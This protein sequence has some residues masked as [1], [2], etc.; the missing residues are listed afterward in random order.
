MRKQPTVES[1]DL[2]VLGGTVL[3]VDARDTVVSD[4]AVAI[5]DGAIVEVGPR[6]K[7]ERRFRARRSIDARGRLVLP[8]F[9]NAHTH[10]AMTL[11]RGVRDDV[12]LMTWL[13]KYM[14]PLERRFVTREFVRWGTRLACWEMIASGTTTF[15][16]GYFF[17]E[18]VA[19]AVDEAGLRVIAGQGIFDVPTPDSNGAAEG[20][21]RG[22][23]FLSDWTGHPRVTPALAPHA[24]YTVG[25]RTFQKTVG[26]AARFEA[27]VLTHVSESD[28][29]LAMV[30]ERYGTTPVR[31]LAALGLL[32][33]SLT[34][35]HCVRVDEEEI[36]LL[37]AGVVGVVHCPESNMKLASGV[38]PVPEMLAAGAR[39]GL[40]TDG[41]ASNNDLDMIG[42]MGSAARVHKVASLDPTAVPAR[43]VLRMATQGGADALHVG[44][45]IGSLETGKRADL[46]VLDV[47]GPNALPLFDPTSHVVYSARSDAVQTVVV[48]GKVLMDRRRL[49]TLDTK[50]IRNQVTR[51]GRRI[52]S[53]LA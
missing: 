15:A 53:A 45:R 49:R 32:G 34:A 4:G 16:D 50:E 48:E 2:L 1:V 51:F 33:P 20:L 25:P 17:E 46:I 30:S 37:A 44:E 18:E 29:E 7:L 38:A 5:R 10:A 11:L 43:V 23:R 27:P 35:A 12:L 24:C 19:R 13:E 9:V 26:L 39:V 8:G 41:A 31:H 21:A 28:G 47:S 22:E 36:A 40:G 3:T 6:S 52:R 14:F 42:E